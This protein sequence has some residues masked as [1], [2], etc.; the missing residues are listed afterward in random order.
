MNTGRQL[1]PDSEATEALVSPLMLRPDCKAKCTYDL[2][3]GQIFLIWSV[4]I[5]FSVLDYFYKGTSEFTKR[6]ASY[7]YFFLYAVTRG[8]HVIVRFMHLL[9]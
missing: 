1:W 4:E 2:R 7:C 6:I 8:R 3:L 9:N 5:V